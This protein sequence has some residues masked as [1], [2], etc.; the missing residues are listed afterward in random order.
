M[1]EKRNAVTEKKQLNVLID[2]SPLAS[3]HAIRGIGVYTR[4]LVEELEQLPGVNVAR[5][6]ALHDATFK[7]DIIHYPYFDLFFNTLPFFSKTKRV[8]T[9]HDVIPLRFPKHYP[10]GKKGSLVVRKQKL[11]LKNVQA[12][13][14]D[15]AASKTDI[16]ELLGVPEPKVFVVHLAAQ[17]AFKVATTATIKEVR[18]RYQLPQQ[19]LL[20]VGDINYN[21][22]IPQLIK[23]LKLLPEHIHLLCVGKNFYPQAIPEWQAIERQIALSDVSQRVQ[24]L[25]EITGDAVP[26]LA[27]LYSAAL[28]Y[29]QPSLY[30]GFGLPVLEAMACRTPVI[31]GSNSSLLEVAGAYALSVSTVP[32]A[33]EIAKKVEELQ[34]WSKNRRQEWTRAAYAWSQEFSW[35]KTAQDTLAV[36][37][38]V[39]G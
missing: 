26:T 24:F 20:Y 6:S 32:Q 33:E 15:S 8:V 17:A 4:L 13:I 16:V 39:L 14:T 31:C 2:T 9:I 36:Y 34:D 1:G 5:S 21:K 11:A 12:V 18:K 23:A 29:V 38:K 19:Y 7:A 10:P 3:G 25:T 28:A 30:E 22:N 37:Q 27:A 35:E